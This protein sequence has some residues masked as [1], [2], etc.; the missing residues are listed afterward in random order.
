MNANS[1]V[2]KFCKKIKFG[3]LERPTVLLGL[4]L[5]EDSDFIIFRTANGKHHINKRNVIDIK[6]TDIEFKENG[7]L[8][9]DI[10]C[11]VY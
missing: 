6:D 5:S 11:Q 8:I 2:I 1:K 10:D 9:N 4:I 7:G 3:D